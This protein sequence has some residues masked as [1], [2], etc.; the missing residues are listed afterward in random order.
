MGRLGS[1]RARSA[2]L[3]APPT[4]RQTDAP[5]HAD[6][7]SASRPLS[8]TDRDTRR[9]THSRAHILP[10]ACLS[11][12]RCLEPVLAGKCGALVGAFCVRSREALVRGLLRGGN[13]TDTSNPRDP[14][15]RARPRHAPR[16]AP[17]R[18]EVG[19][20]GK[21]GRLALGTTEGAAATPRALRSCVVPGRDPDSGPGPSLCGPTWCAA[22]SCSASPE[23]EP[24]RGEMEMGTSLLITKL[25][26]P[27]TL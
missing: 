20:P 25:Y 3:R 14:G 16:R 27:P 12:R 24:P 4:D 7:P 19:S 8:H 22:L 18:L 17:G 9:H 26:L 2:G 13:K 15:A 6:A 10:P 23:S 21:G 5:A 1:E 11:A